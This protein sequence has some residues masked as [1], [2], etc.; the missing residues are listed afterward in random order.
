MSR[1]N[2]TL[3]IIIRDKLLNAFCFIQISA[4][5]GTFHGDKISA[6]TIFKLKYLQFQY[7]KSQN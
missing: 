3:K 4:K 5:K 2:K 7:E 6:N 1:F